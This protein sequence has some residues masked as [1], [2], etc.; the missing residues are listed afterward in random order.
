LENLGFLK[1]TWVKGAVAGVVLWPL[2]LLLAAW[3]SMHP[4]EK[5][6]LT[7]ELVQGSLKVSAACLLFFIASPQHPIARLLCAPWLR[8]CGIISYEW[9]LFH[10]PLAL[11]SR[12]HFGPARGNPFEYVLIVGTPLLVGL[13]LSAAVY[14][15]F[16][17]P[18][19][20]YGRE[21]N[22]H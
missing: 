21:K 18:I 2:A 6:F 10:Q 1:K 14:R 12:A 8:W 13:V 16:S 20:R 17:L 15:F 19:L 22:Q 5:T 9:Y 4:T 11:W 3:A 7:N